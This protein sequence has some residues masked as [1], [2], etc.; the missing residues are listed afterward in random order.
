M[1]IL[2]AHPVTRVVRGLTYRFFDGVSVLMALEDL[3]GPVYDP[4]AG[5]MAMT[6]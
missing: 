4:D 6:V 3:G 5:M 1:I 2:G